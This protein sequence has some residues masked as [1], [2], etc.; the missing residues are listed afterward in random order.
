MTTL[1]LAGPRRSTLDRPTAMRL[2]ATEYQRYTEHLRRLSTED[3]GRSTDCPDWDVRQMATH[4]LGMAKMAASIRE[5]ARQRKT[6]REHMKANGGLFI[7]ALT[8]L[9]VTEHAT[10]RPS[11][12]V[13][14]LAAT[15][16]KAARGRRRTPWFIRRS[17]LPD[18]EP[19]PGVHEKWTV[20]YLID[21][22]LTRD[23]WLHRVDS[24]RGTG[25]PMELTPEHDGVLVA[26]VVTEWLAR[27][28]RP[29]TVRLS[30]PA[31]GEWTQGADGERIEL[32][33]IEFCRVISGRGKGTGLLAVQVPF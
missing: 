7:D 23:P 22:I 19:M 18:P 25:V 26:D 8:G 12:I 4:V 27:H 15:G 10:L 28:G 14:Q 30:G 32:D 33:A 11:E 1:V 2:A 31:G 6:A 29:C 5:G 9:Q 24:T 16:P 3:W 17:Q 13:E 21:T 20:G